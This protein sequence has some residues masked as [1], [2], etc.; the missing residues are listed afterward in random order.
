MYVFPRLDGQKQDRATDTAMC[1]AFKNAGLGSGGLH[2]FRHTFATRFIANG[3]SVADLQELLGH[4]NL[5]TTKRSVI[6][7]C[8]TPT[9]V[10]GIP[11]AISRRT[12]L[13]DMLSMA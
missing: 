7:G 10:L 4:S 13:P 12:V 8:T 9:K 6:E 1:V 5:E 2:M 3:G 11:L